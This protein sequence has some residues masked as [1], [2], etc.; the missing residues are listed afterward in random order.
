MSWRTP[1]AAD[2]QRLQPNPGGLPT[3]SF[4]RAPTQPYGAST[5]TFQGSGE[6]L[7]T[8]DLSLPGFASFAPPNLPGHAPFAPLP[9][10]TGAN[11]WHG[12]GSL[13]AGPDPRYAYVPHA[14]PQLM[15]PHPNPTTGRFI[16]ISHS[17]GGLTRF[18]DH[19][20]SICVNAAHY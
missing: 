18:I 9:T 13:L 2:N 15:Q 12:E 19:F 16:D 17:R 7:P 10:T 20:R 6:L 4:S 11:A 3:Q 8:S 5:S 1:P 14:D